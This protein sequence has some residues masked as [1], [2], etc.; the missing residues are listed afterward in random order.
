MGAW[1]QQR[2]RKQ[3]A[4]PGGPTSGQLRQPGA[5]RG[6]HASSSGA[7]DC[8]VWRAGGHGIARKHGASRREEA[9]QVYSPRRKQIVEATRR[10]AGAAVQAAAEAVVWMVTQAGV[11]PCKRGMGS[12]LSGNQD[13]R[14]AG[15]ASGK[16]HTGSLQSGKQHGSGQVAVGVACMV[17][18][19]VA[20]DGQQPTGRTITG[21]SGEWLCWRLR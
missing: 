20:T 14:G 5:C 6:G 17:T 8:A 7:A 1:R 12:S 4:S 11:V 15:C 13:A 9:G 2:Q 21:A 16:S 3:P 18:V 10:R 19:I